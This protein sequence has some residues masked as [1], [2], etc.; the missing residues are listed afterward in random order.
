MRAARSELWSQ[1]ADAGRVLA[2]FAGEPD[3]DPLLDAL[4]LDPDDTAATLANAEALL[5]DPTATSVSVY[6]K[7]Y[8]R[9]DGHVG[10]HMNDALYQP[11]ETRRQIRDLASVLLSSDDLDVR[12]GAEEMLTWMTVP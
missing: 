2:Q 6:L 4:L 12:A 5:Q 9:A 1:R 10:D 7:A 11:P 8:S 3:I